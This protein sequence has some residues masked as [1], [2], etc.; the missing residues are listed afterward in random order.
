MERE[1]GRKTER[2]GE[3]R[4]GEGGER[5]HHTAKSQREKAL[6]VRGHSETRD[7]L[8]KDRERHREGEKETVRDAFT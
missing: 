8:G 3:R 7:R 4:E 1:A 5:K 2:K 6:G